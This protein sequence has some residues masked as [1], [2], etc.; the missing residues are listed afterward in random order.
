MS[1]ARALAAWILLALAVSSCTGDPPQPEGDTPP[2]GGL[3]VLS[4]SPHTTEIIFMIGAGDQL[5]GVTDFCIFPDEA[6]AVTKVGGYMDPNL[7]LM[8]R[9]APDMAFHGPGER[10]LE[11]KLAERGVELVSVPNNTMAEILDGIL[12]VGAKLGR[13]EQA[14]AVRGQLEEVIAAVRTRTDGRERPVVLVVIGRPAGPVRQVF[15][16]GPGTFLD[17][18]ITIAGGRN[19]MADAATPYPTVS[20]ESLAA[21]PPHVVIEVRTEAPPTGVKSERA[22]EEWMRVLGPRA[23]GRTRVVQ[24]F[25]PHLTVP[26]PGIGPSIER[27]A[28]VIHHDLAAGAE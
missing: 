6:Q 20:L 16:T 15:S 5:V 8:L 7:E 17:E 3:R 19:S 18:L 25:D 27:L 9:L 23:E 22:R 1:S 11:Q 10:P 13:E 26:G 28:G 4:L 24:H 2:T 14:R 12:A 21:D